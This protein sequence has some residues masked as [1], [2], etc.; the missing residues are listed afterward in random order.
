M[1]GILRIRCTVLAH[2][3]TGHNIGSPDRNMCMHTSRLSFFWKTNLIRTKSDDRN[4][5]SEW[6][7][8]LVPFLKIT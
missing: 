1:L 4:V 5:G 8:M 3:I 7:T 2:A 6:L